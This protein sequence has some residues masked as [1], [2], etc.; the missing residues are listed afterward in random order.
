MKFLDKTYFKFRNRFSCLLPITYNFCERRKAFFKF[1]IAGGLSS[2]VDIFLLFFFHGFLY[3]NL[4]V[5]TTL[6]YILSF[7]LS[8]FLQKIWTFRDFNRE[9]VFRQFMLY[10]PSVFIALNLN[11]LFM[12]ILVN[13]F[14]ILY[15]LAQ[16]LVNT[17]I[18]LMNFFVY[19]FVIFK[20]EIK[21]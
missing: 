14:N 10:I 16:L 13:K 17:V 12:H 19:K 7:L 6:A 5:A 4:V 8:F 21:I 1:F 2:L 11:A 9:R 18:G 3:I 20:K 15:L